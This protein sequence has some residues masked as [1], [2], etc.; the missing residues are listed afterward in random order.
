MECG[1]GYTFF[2]VGKPAGVRREGG[3]GFAIRTALVDQIDCPS[4]IYDRIMKVRFPLS[5][6]RYLSILSV[7]APTMQASEDTL[8]SFY[9]ALRSAVNSVP[10]EEKLIVLGD[11]NARVGRDNQTWDALGRYGVGK[12]N[13]N[14]LRLLELCSECDLVVCNTFFR[15]K[16]KHKATWTHPR[17]KI[18]H[19]IDFIITRQS[20]LADVCSMRVLRSADCDTD[21]KLVRCKLKLRIR[22]R[23]RMNGVKAPKRIDVAKLK[24]P[25]VT[26]SLRAK[27]DD[28]EF[29][30]SWN[31][32]KEQVYNA[33]V[34]HLGFRKKAYKDWFDESS[35]AIC[36]LLRTKLD[37]HVALLNECSS[38]K[39][40]AERVYKE[41]KYLLQRELRRL[42]K[43][44]WLKI[45]MQAQKAFDV[46]DLKSLYDILNASYG[47]KASSVAPLRSRDNITL[48]KDPN[49]ILDRWQEHF[50]NLFDIP[51]EVNMAAIDGL[52][53]REL[54][55]DLEKSPSLEEVLSCIKRVKKDKAPGIDGIPIEL[56]QVDSETVTKA[57]F[58]LITAGW[59]GSPIPQDWVD[60][61]LVVL[62]K[63]KASKDV[64]DHYRGIMLLEVAGKVLSR[65]LV[66]RL[67]ESICPKVIPESQSGFRSGRGT[68]DAIFS[69][70]QIQEKCVE[71][72]VPLYQVFVDFK[73][74]FDSVN[75]NALWVVLGKVG[76]PPRFVDM[77]KQLHRN[78]IARVSCNGRLS[79][80]V[81]VDNGVKQGDIVA[82]TLFSIYLAV[83]LSHAFHDCDKGILMHF[84]TTG[85]VFNL[86]RFSAQSKTFQ[87]LVRELLY[88]DDA[89]LLAHSAEDMQQLI[90]L[91]SAGSTTFGLTIS[92]DKTKV[93]FTPA[94]GAA[95]V[96]PSIFVY[97]AM[98]GVV[99]NF[100]YL[101][102]TLSRDASLDAEIHFRIR[103]AS[104]AFGKLEKRL[105]ADRGIS[106][107]TKLAVY[108][109]C[110]LTTLLYA[111]E[112][113]TV[114][115]RHIKLLERFHQKCLRR[116]LSI[117]WHT[118]TSDTE[119]LERAQC[120]SVATMILSNQMRW[121]G[122]VI[123]MGDERLPKQMFYG[124]LTAGARPQHK[125]R[126][127]YKDCIK[128]N[129]KRLRIHVD[130]WEKTAEDRVLW[131]SAVS[132]GSRDFEARLIAHKKLKRDLR[133]GVVNDV[134]ACAA[135]WPCEKCGRLLLSKAGY[136]NHLKSHNHHPRRDGL[137][138]RHGQQQ[139]LMCNK[140]CKSVAGL[141]R[142][143]AVH[144][145]EAGKHN[146]INSARSL[147]FTCHIC[148]KAC[149]SSA[150]LK[151]HL[152]GHE[153]KLIAE[154]PRNI[155]EEQDGYHL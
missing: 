113:W 100:V 43:T 131:R 21:H 61:V 130:T 135:R 123:R 136:V 133:K 72:H 62:H 38:N 9:D 49:K 29:D 20:D 80:P 32:F 34:E 78:M 104:G 125:P 71:Q 23:M 51:S 8:I 126:K 122:H 138:S 146:A 91:L 90:D 111:S 149:K 60:G 127:R 93:M 85:R 30:G 83:M 101:G 106:N 142:H 63:G 154:F 7:Y 22:K 55:Y 39:S 50:A 69:A 31:T 99:D 52:R 1:A 128:V 11:F 143:M 134:S 15:Q 95:Y 65:L 115:Q 56:L 94:P 153:R 40:A 70:R 54:N 102:S 17:S 84:R 155:G 107:K 150:G 114:L 75:R 76:C 37:L 120:C 14:G 81:R 44:W 140:A 35:P 112:T 105:W 33:G 147:F 6:G 45:S 58:N 117:K 2:W 79:D 118:P 89:N 5:C 92:V 137:A 16:L 19:M 96:K 145:G 148:F 48:I 152:R 4:S 26:E 129:L 88:A 119:V 124:E 121:T 28:M 141:Q 24:L 59:N 66:D 98:L 144:K 151:S 108:K 77:L 103:N 109:S 57:L 97:G 18:G 47:P 116:I 87:V 3:V 42:K 64:C 110:V 86:R 27:L 73:K 132:E 10:K 12:M 13:T 36:E 67:L 139:C 82:P 74:A 41:H 25:G 46:R 68:V 53:Q